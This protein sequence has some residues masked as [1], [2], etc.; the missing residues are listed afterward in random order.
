MQI[1]PK[2]TLAFI[3]DSITDCG[4]TRPVGEASGLGNGYVALFDAAW[5][6]RYPEHGLRV[7]NFGVSG[8]TIRDVA[9]RW[10]DA[11]D[12]QAETVALMI[13]IN[14]VWRQFDRPDRP[15][16]GVP[17]EEYTQTLDRLIRDLGV[18]KRAAVLLTPFFIEPNRSEP[19]RAMMDR[20]GDVVKGVAGHYGVACLD[21]QQV[22]DRLLATMHP[23]ALADDRVHPRMTGH[24]A[25]ALALLD[26][27]QP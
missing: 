21:T 16:L 9:K 18:R 27:L 26:A 7:L 4:R 14:D 23:Y 22:F 3:G 17:L 2:S 19:M 25:L 8:D 15:E 20:Y 6:V 24:M 1:A 10:G 11:I 5:R 13:G 12:N